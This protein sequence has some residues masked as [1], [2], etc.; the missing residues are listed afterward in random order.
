M[1]VR[2]RLAIIIEG[3]VANLD[4]SFISNSACRKE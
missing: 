4:L 1:G 3:H 2:D